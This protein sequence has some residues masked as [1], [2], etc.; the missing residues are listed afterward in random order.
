MSNTSEELRRELDES[1]RK[2]LGLRYE[3][4]AACALDDVLEVAKSAIIRIE[5]LERGIEKASTDAHV[6]GDGAWFLASDLDKYGGFIEGRKLYPTLLSLIET[7][8][9]EG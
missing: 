7:L 5:Q 2:L 6:G 4:K 1:E 9:E 3:V 8:G